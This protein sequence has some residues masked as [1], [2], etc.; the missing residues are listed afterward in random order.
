MP[1]AS[2]PAPVDTGRVTGRRT[3]RFNTPPEM[4]ADVA[5]LVEA[6]RAGRLTHVGNWSLGQALNHLGAWANFAFEPHPLNPPFFVRWIVGMRKSKYLNVGIPPGVRIPNVDGGTVVCEP[7]NLE[8][9]LARFNASWAKLKKET[10]TRPNVIFGK[11]THQEWINLN[12][13]HAEL[14]L[15]FFKL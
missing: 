6:E 5:K 11:L 14:H 1:T 7:T 2:T 15:S 8:E 10:P 9:G 4:E 13:R 12:L 3:L